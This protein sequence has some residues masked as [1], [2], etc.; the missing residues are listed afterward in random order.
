MVPPAL[1]RLNLIGETSPQVAGTGNWILAPRREVII[2]RKA[3][4]RNPVAFC[5]DLTNI[6]GATLPLSTAVSVFGQSIDF[7]LTAPDR[8]MVWADF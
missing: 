2:T 3:M 6:N 8:H 5:A 1:W 7:A 4:C